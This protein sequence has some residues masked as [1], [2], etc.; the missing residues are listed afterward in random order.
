MQSFH[1]WW[2]WHPM[3]PVSVVSLGKRHKETHFG[4]LD[5]RNAVVLLMMLSA[6]ML[7]TPM[8]MASHD[9]KGQVVP[10][11]NCLD[12]RN[13]MIPLMMSLASPDVSAIGFT[14]PKCHVSPHFC[15]LKLRN[16]IVQ[17]VM[18]LTSCGRDAH[19][20]GIIWT[21]SHVVL[22]FDCLDIGNVVVP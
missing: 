20:N 13:A 17:L 12:L 5:L 18:L 7:L 3:M 19:G 2:H 6:S 14:W 9:Q 10:H 22:H 16:A 21:K 15:Y 1:W 4:H 11:F 8:P